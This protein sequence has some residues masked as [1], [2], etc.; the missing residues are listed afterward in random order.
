MNW[1]TPDDEE[2]SYLRADPLLVEQELDVRPDVAAAVERST[3]IR[4]GRVYWRSAHDHLYALELGDLGRGRPSTATVFGHWERYEPRP[5]EHEID[6]DLLDFLLWFA[7]ASGSI[8]PADVRRVAGFAGISTAWPEGS[9][10]RTPEDRF[11]DL[12]EFAYEPRFVE[13]EGLRMSYVESGQ[14]DPILCLHGEPTWGYLY[15]HMIPTLASIGRVV[16]PDLIGFGRSDKPVADNAYSYR[17]HARW[18]RRFVEALDLR[19]ITL[20]CQDWGGLLGLRVLAQ[21]PE[22]FARVVAM[23]TGFPTGER[24]PGPAFMTWRLYSQRQRALNLPAMM[25]SAVRGRTLTDAEA[26]AYAAPFPSAEYQ[27]AA[28]VFPRLVPVRPDHPG[29]YDNRRAVAVLRSLEIPVLLPWADG[30]A[31]TGRDGGGLRA[32]FKNAAP[33]ITI[34]GAGHFIQEDRGEQVA[35]QIARW[36]GRPAQA[37]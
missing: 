25:R 9:V 3:G 37:S 7:A 13:V 20:V 36:M 18:L 10:L 30:D 23:N 34:A 8:D 35:E 11:D 28:L 26:A 17:S 2:L 22:R 6:A 19:Q 4:A 29:A 27:T 14:G 31:V 24:R 16:V 12:P 5:P 32:I 15:R 21:A 1:I 33:P